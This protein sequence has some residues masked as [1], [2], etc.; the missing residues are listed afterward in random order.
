[1]KNTTVVT[2]SASGIG[3]AVRTR[4]EK[5]GDKVI[6]ID[7]RNAEIIADLSTEDGRKAAISVVSQCC[8]GRLDRFVAAAGVGPYVKNPALIA[9]VNYFGAV[10]LLDGLFDCLKQG[11]MPSAVVISSN[12]AQMRSWNDDPYVLALLNHNEMEALPALNDP[13]ISRAFHVGS[14]HII[15]EPGDSRPAYGGSKNAVARAVRRRA[16]IWGA[17][18]VRLNAIAPGT[19]KTPMLQKVLEDPILTEGARAAYR[20]LGRDAEP[21]E[22]AAVVVFLLSPEASFCHG[23]VYYVDGGIDALIRPDSF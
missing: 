2:S 14:T 9:A 13:S 4:L 18:G 11:N 17:A 1:V 3:A 7:L 23:A 19:T 6:G 16:M 15:Y 22:I 12:S 5:Q 8:D 10:D 20:P 21:E